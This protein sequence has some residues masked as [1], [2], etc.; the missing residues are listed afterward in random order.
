MVLIFKNTRFL[1]RDLPNAKTLNYDKPA[2]AI[3]NGN[4]T[5]I[6]K[7]WQQETYYVFRCR[8]KL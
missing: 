4:I 3:G 2:F 8:L 1:F 7:K 6:Q 5:K